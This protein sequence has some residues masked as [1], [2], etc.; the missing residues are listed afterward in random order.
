MEQ[1]QL[2]LELSYFDLEGRT[3]TIMGPDRKQK[4]GTVNL[5]N[6]TFIPMVA[7]GNLKIGANTTSNNG[8]DYWTT[9]L[10]DNVQYLDEEEPNCYTF[11]GSDNSEYYIQRITKN[12]NI[13][14]N[15]SCLDFHYRF[16]VWDNR[17]K[18]LDGNPPP[19]YVRK[20]QTRPSVNPMQSPGLCK[21]IIGLMDDL[22]SQN[23][24]A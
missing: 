24:F 5:Q 8:H 3:N 23:L 14:V 19:P 4:A 10:I 1:K 18:A 13:K 2:L 21:H 6:L 20:T 17:F 22:R 7:N 9:I 12:S 15:C 11:E 16:S